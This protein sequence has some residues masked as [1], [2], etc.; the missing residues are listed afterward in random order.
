[1]AN[2]APLNI[3]A[4]AVEASIDLTKL[5][6]ALLATPEALYV[7]PD[8]TSTRFGPNAEGQGSKVQVDRLRPIESPDPDNL[9][10]YV[11]S[12]GPTDIDIDV[13]GNMQALEWDVVTIQVER[14]RMP[15]PVAEKFKTRQLSQVDT[16]M[17]TRI[18]IQR[19]YHEFLDDLC[20]EEYRSSVSSDI[21]GNNKASAALMTNDPNPTTGDGLSVGMLK[22]FKRRASL[23]RTRAFGSVPGSD[24]QA[25]TGTYNAITSQVG[26]NELSEDPLWRDYVIRDPSGERG[27]LVKGFIGEFEQ[28]TVVKSDRTRTSTVGPS[29][30][31]F[32]GNEIIFMASDPTLIDG[33]SLEDDT[34]VQGFMGEFPVV[35][36][37]VGNPEVKRAAEDKFGENLILDWFHTLGVKAT[38]SLS[39]A[40]A[41]LLG[42]LLGV[43]VYTGGSRFIIRG[44]FA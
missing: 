28:V 21:F 36:T 1:M 15:K 10:A 40:D 42:T 38:E 4:P 41:T 29:G 30:S 16:E 34:T 43:S 18:N 2:A 9:A 17:A 27:R 23:L 44:L 22:E 6:D 39:N 8:Y 3:G 32:S 11:A 14:Y 33:G 31:T 20:R 13:A 25:L 35:L 12:T 5:A 26:I 37:M 7:W 24:A 19:N